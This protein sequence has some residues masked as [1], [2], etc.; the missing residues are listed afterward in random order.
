MA[1]SAALSALAAAL[2]ARIASS[3]S[4]TGY[5]LLFRGLRVRTLLR[6][7]PRLRLFLSFLILTFLELPPARQL[8]S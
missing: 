7:K 5:G 8:K 1:R 3:A 2:A 4:Y 6:L